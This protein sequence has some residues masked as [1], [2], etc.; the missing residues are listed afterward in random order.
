MLAW[1][2][3]WREVQTCIW[4]SWCHCH[5][6]SLASV[7]S[8]LVLPFRYWLTRVVLEKTH[9]TGVRQCLSGCAQTDNGKHS[10]E[11]DWYTT[12]IY[13]FLST[14]SFVCSFFKSQSAVSAL[15]VQYAEEGLCN[16]RASVCPSVQAAAGLLLCTR[17][18]GD[19]DRLLH[20][21]WPAVSS[22]R[23]AANAGSATLSAARWKLDTDLF[24][25]YHYRP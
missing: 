23:A 10:C 14:L 13:I 25:P 12:D 24:I 2:S 22:S 20:G 8:R 6:L 16:G 4:P 11:N 17:R 1:L 7:K 3:V 21:R 18:A 19:V 15:P 9:Q 5:S